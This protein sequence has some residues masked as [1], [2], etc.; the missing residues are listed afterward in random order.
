M[1]FGRV[2]LTVCAAAGLVASCGTSSPAPGAGEELPPTPSTSAPPQTPSTTTVPQ[3]R[4]T[5]TFP[6]VDVTKITL[7]PDGKYP[8]IDQAETKRQDLEP[9]TYRVRL[10][11]Q[12]DWPEQCLDEL[13][14]FSSPPE[15]EDMPDEIKTADDP[16]L[17]PGWEASAVATVDKIRELREPVCLEYWEKWEASWPDADKP[18]EPDRL[19]PTTTLPE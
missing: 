3:Q 12:A 4:T 1:T 13:V 7:A 2:A 16:I 17:K 19:P 5:E 18:P 15:G 10:E 14:V 11:H 8:V 9:G 6:A